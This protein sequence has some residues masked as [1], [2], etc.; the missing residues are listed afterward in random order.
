MNLYNIQLRLTNKHLTTVLYHEH[1]R[2]PSISTQ[3]EAPPLMPRLLL[4]EASPVPSSSPSSFCARTNRTSSFTARELYDDV[5]CC[6][7]GRCTIGPIV[8]PLYEHI[9]NDTGCYRRT[10]IQDARRNLRPSPPPPPPPAT[11]DESMSSHPLA[12]GLSAYDDDR[13]TSSSRD[14]RRRTSLC[15]L[16]FVCR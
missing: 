13:G 7:A 9:E 15:G 11:A 2:P 4:P 16:G 5:R 12:V 1:Y 10:R 8:S 3:I 6:D 14:C